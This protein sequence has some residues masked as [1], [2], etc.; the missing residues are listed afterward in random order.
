[1]CQCGRRLRVWAYSFPKKFSLDEEDRAFLSFTKFHRLLDC[2]ERVCDLDSE[3][4]QTP[5]DRTVIRTHTHTSVEEA[6]HDLL[7]PYAI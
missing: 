1:M 3:G 2:D 7:G 5:S 4:L 6:E